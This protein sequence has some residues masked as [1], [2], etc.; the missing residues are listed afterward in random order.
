MGKAFQEK[1]KKNGE[2]DTRALR[3]SLCAK[4]P[5]MRTKKEVGKGKQK[6]RKRKSKKKMLPKGGIEPP[7]PRPQRGVL[8]TIRLELF[9]ALVLC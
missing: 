8:T 7:F 6:K 5:V 1:M 9:F 3:K 2:D 4:F